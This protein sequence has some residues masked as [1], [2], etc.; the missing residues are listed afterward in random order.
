MV[1]E[2]VASVSEVRVGLLLGAGRP[3]KARLSA[4][5]TIYLAIFVATTFTSLLFILGDNI[6][7]WMTTDTT[8]QRLMLELIPLFGIGN[9]A[10]AVGTQAWTIVG[11]QGRYRLSTAVGAGGSWLITIPLAV[12]STVVLKVDLQGQTAAVVIGYMASS[13]LNSYIMFTSD[14]EK[15]SLQV[16]EDQDGNIESDSSSSSSDSDSDE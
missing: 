1:T 13:T 14:W 3:E 7:Y 16:R 12:I 4:Y 5:K 6:P 8:L 10:L 11:A 15:L 2:A 9:I